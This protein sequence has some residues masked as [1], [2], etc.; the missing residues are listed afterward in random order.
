MKRKLIGWTTAG[1][2]GAGL[3]AGVASAATNTANTANT[4]NTV[5]TANTATP[6]LTAANTG[7]SNTGLSSKALTRA[8]HKLARGAARGEVVFDTKK[9]VTTVDFQRGTISDA[10][11]SAITVTDKTGTAQTWVISSATKVRERGV[12]SPQLTDDENAVVVGVKSDGRLDARLVF[13]VPAKA[14]AATSGQP[15]T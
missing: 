5:N 2:A 3:F 8:E 14:S 1:L 10:S 13:I 7:L 6:A 9:G 12:S 4:A 11:S 15:T